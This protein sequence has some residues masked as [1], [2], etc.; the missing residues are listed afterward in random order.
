MTVKLETPKPLTSIYLARGTD[1]L[2]EYRPWFTGD[3]FE[4]RTGTNSTRFFLLQHPCSL[5]VDGN[6]FEEQLLMAQIIEGKNHRS[7]WNKHAFTEMPLPELMYGD[8]TKYVVSFRKLK[9]VEP[10]RLDDSHERIASLSS[11]GVNLLLQRWIF[12]NSRVIIPT[13]TY[14]E[15]IAGPFNEAELEAEWCSELE[16]TVHANSVSF[17]NWIRSKSEG[18]DIPR[19]VML[20]NPQQRSFVRREMSREIDE[21]IEYTS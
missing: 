6:A 14:E 16:G 4:D 12:Q 2:D 10:E 11:Y 15:Q 9:L 8:D 13:K 3:V 7:D 17:H 18:A 21:I 20:E 1:E 19:Q 5:R